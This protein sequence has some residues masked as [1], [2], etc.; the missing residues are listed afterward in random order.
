MEKR[1]TKQKFCE[2]KLPNFWLTLFALCFTFVFVFAG[3]NRDINEKPKYENRL[4]DDYHT[5]SP[6]Q[7]NRPTTTEEIDDFLDWPEEG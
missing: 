6:L 7:N 4:R 1:R 3:P 5:S 2:I